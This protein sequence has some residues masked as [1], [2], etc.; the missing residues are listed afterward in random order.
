MLTEL[1]IVFVTETVTNQDG[2]I[3]EIEVFDSFL[4][5]DGDG[6]SDHLDDDDDNDGRS[7]ANEITI[8]GAGITIFPD[9]DE[10]GIP[11]YLDSDS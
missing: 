1:E 7:T 8:N 4:D 3:E 6:I 11:D 5:T 10:D 9:T 2:K